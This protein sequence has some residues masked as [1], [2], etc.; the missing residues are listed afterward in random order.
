MY[1]YQRM[2]DRD[3]EIMYNFVVNTPHVDT[4]HFLLIGH[5][6]RSHVEGKV[7]PPAL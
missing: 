1:I 3:L 6:C 5:L 2:S 7:I 4:L